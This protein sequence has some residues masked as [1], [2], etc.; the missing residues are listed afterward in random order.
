MS[1]WMYL[2]G[3]LLTVATLT[4]LMRDVPGYEFEGKCCFAV[5][6]VAKA[7]KFPGGSKSLLK[8]LRERSE[9]EDF[10]FDVGE[11]G[12]QRRRFQSDAVRVFPFGGGESKAYKDLTEVDGRFVPRYLCKA[13]GVWPVVVW[14]WTELPVFEETRRQI[15][16]VSGFRFVTD[17]APGGV[18]ELRR[19]GVD[20][21]ARLKELS[22][23]VRE[24]Q[25][26]VDK[27]EYRSVMQDRRLRAT[28]EMLSSSNPE[29]EGLG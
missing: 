4:H 2:C 17:G 11:E 14:P 13:S 27:I 6:D 22:G 23:L 19:Q 20:V 9:Y 8:E 29:P 15:G 1:G 10:L 16:S 3:E 7:L 25:R 18:L 21:D 5:A 24:M 28:G 12:D 26:K